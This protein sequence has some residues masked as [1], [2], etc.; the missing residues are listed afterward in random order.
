MDESTNPGVTMR[1][2][3]VDEASDPSLFKKHGTSIVGTEGCS[4]FF[5]LG[6][7]DIEEPQIVGSSDVLGGFIW[8]A[9]NDGGW[10]SS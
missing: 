4:K 7:A 10:P 8:R 3:F 2:Y 6:M 5:I 9:M 1:H